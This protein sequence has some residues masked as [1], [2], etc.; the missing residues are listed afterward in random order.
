MQLPGLENQ[1]IYKLE[2]MDT[3]DGGEECAVNG[4][5]IGHALTQRLSDPSEREVIV[6]R[7]RD[8]NTHARWSHCH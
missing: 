2:E 7:C 1:G 6:R 4:L 8:G 3:L 5:M